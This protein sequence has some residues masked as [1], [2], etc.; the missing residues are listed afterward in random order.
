MLADAAA[1]V[2]LTQEHLADELP[3]QGEL[4]VCVDTDAALIHALPDRAPSTRVSPD[5]LAYVIYTSG[6]TGQPKGTLLTHRG[7]CN[8][9]QAAVLEHG[10]GPSSRVLQFASA[11]FDASVCE[12]FSTLLAGGELVLAPRESL[13]P[14]PL[15]A[16]VAEREINAVTLT[17]SVLAQLAPA[18]VPGL[19]TII[20]AGEACPPELAARWTPGRRFLNAY[21]PTEITICASINKDV[22]PAHPTLGRP[23]PNVKVYVLDEQMAL[24]PVG[25]PGEL[26]VGGAGVARGYLNRPELTA[27]ALRAGS[28]LR[29]AGRAAVPHRRSRPAP[30]VGGA[31]L[32]RARG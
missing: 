22:D 5:N 18:D 4:M 11:S 30:A 7:L 26:Y 1:A 25:M 14:G 29:R 10:F 2:L 31:G 16:L 21:G 20:S 17:P 6:S 24:V 13:L 15:Q 27:D 32:P 3:S 23:F 28:V 9:A 12:V 19:R 8:T